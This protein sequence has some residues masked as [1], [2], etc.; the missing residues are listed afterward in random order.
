L[1]HTPVQNAPK[2]WLPTA[3]EREEEEEEKEEE[4]G[5]RKRHVLNQTDWCFLVFSLGVIYGLIT[6]RG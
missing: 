2:S 5:E 6:H 1:I 3:I 4:E